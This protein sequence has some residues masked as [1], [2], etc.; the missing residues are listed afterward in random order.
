MKKIKILFL[1]RQPVTED[2][3]AASFLG[4][5][6]YQRLHRATGNSLFYRSGHQRY[7]NVRYSLP[8]GAVPVV[9]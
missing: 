9:F 7:K 5:R 8:E 1:S 6:F 3:L 2:Q 4:Y